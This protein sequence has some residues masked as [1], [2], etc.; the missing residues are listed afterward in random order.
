MNLHIQT[1]GRLNKFIFTKM[2]PKITI[3]AI[4]GLLK[5]S[6]LLKT[7]ISLLIQNTGPKE[8]IEINLNF[9]GDSKEISNFGCI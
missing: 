1:G 7:I 5:L 3:I 2:I 4:D 6:I 9:I 8:V